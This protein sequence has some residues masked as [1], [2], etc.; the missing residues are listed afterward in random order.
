VQGWNEQNMSWG[1]GIEIIKCHNIFIAKDN[2][3]WDF[4]L[5]NFAEDA[6]GI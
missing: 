4:T 1:L 2:F 5:D 3:C 6:I